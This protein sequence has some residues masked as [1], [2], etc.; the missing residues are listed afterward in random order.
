MTVAAIVLTLNEERHIGRCLQ[1]L[2]GLADWVYVVDS[3]SKDNTI[4]IARQHGSRVLEHAWV[5]HGHQFNW[6]LDQLD[7]KPDW[8]LRL[9]ADEYLAPGSVERLRDVL[10]RAGP[11]VDGILLDCRRTFQ[12]RLLRFGGV[13]RVPMLR[14][15]RYGRGRSEERWMDERIR[16]SGRIIRSRAV[17]V[18]DNQKSLTWW[19]SKHNRYAS[20]E[21]L[22]ILHQRYGLLSRLSGTKGGP[23]PARRQHRLKDRLYM[24]LPGRLRALIY[25]VYRYVLLGGF[26]DGM[27]GTNFHVLQ[28]FWYRFLVDAKVAEVERRVRDAGVDLLVAVEEVLGF[29]P[30]R[31][32]RGHER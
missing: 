30:E 25:F 18:D 16:V 29:C 3:G 24:R 27:A 1:S 23:G 15:F 20:H 26:L 2:A 6:A 14:L 28:A 19:T 31:L 32:R 4:A 17:F 21:A 5:N 11:D 10:S 12:G 22:E 7:P 8:V 13:S 9:D